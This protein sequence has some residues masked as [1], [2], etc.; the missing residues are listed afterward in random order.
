MCV[1]VC[2]CM[3]SWCVFVVVKRVFIILIFFSFQEKYVHVCKRFKIKEKTRKTRRTE[4][5]VAPVIINQSKS[6]RKKI[7]AGFSQNKYKKI[8]K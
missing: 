3:S 1:S 5:Y 2:V 8:K 7:S 4:F 6:I